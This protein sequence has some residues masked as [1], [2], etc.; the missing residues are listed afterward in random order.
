MDPFRLTCEE[1]VSK[2]PVHQGWCSSPCPGCWPPSPRKAGMVRPT[3][4]TGR[5]QLARSTLTVP[6]L[7]GFPDPDLLYGF[8]WWINVHVYW[9]IY[10]YAVL[11]NRQNRHWSCLGKKKL[12]IF[13]II[14]ISSN[15]WLRL[16]LFI[17][18]LQQA[19][20]SEIFFS[21]VSFHR[22]YH[23]TREYGMSYRGLGF[24]AVVWF[25]SSPS[26]SPFSKFSL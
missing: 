26:P 23:N 12:L 3:A 9:K 14:H 22:W 10:F 2:C 16:L 25:G 24:L 5:R 15:I 11:K 17:F 21:S 1:Y 19:S 6:Q 20:Q 7:Q 13:S 18:Y 4:T 8:V